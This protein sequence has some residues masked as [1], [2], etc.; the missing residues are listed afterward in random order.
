MDLFPTILYCLGLKIPKAIDGKLIKEIFYEDFLAQDP[1]EYADHD[2]YRDSGWR[3][4]EKTY[5]RE[6]ESKEIEQA[7]K[8]L[9]Y[10]D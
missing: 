1:V 7:L 4:A 3:I 8:G 6:E 2:I 9:G 10:I 5:E